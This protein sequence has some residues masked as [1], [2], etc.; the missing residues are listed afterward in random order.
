MYIREDLVYNKHTGKLV[1]FVNLGD[2]NNHL[3]KFERSLQNDGQSD[4]LILAKTMMSFMVKCI[5]TA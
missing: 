2:L 4:K 3:L 1:G 5:F